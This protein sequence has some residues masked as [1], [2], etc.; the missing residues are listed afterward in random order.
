MQI[1]GLF[2]M[3][4]PMDSGTLP[5]LIHDLSSLPPCISGIGATWRRQELLAVCDLPGEYQRINSEIV[6]NVSPAVVRRSYVQ[7]WLAASI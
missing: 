6:N 7:S 5:L 2:M 4:I 1:N 3:A